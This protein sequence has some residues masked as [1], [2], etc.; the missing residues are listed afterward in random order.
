MLALIVYSLACTAGILAIFNL[1]RNR[2]RDAKGCRWWAYSVLACGL[3]IEM[4]NAW[5][6]GAPG[7]TSPRWLTA[8]GIGVVLSWAA[9][10]DWLRGRDT[11]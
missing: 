3:A 8:I 5:H 6:N 10:E 9:I 7:W 4:L 1:Q 2:H 11:E